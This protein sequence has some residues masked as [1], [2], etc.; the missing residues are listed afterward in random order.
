MKIKTLFL[1]AITVLV[2]IV[3]MKNTDEI[4]FWIFGDTLISK[5]AILGLMFALGFI[6]GIIAARP[7]KKKISEETEIQ[8]NYPAEHTDNLSDED[9]EYIS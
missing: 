6:A 9:K 1:V 3:L 8:K 5:P 7:F 4:S 2:T